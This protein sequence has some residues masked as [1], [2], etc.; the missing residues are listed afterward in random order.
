MYWKGLR[1]LY[2]YIVRKV[3][4]IFFMLKKSLHTPKE[5]RDYFS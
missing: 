1:N 5:I 3:K 4:T 2:A